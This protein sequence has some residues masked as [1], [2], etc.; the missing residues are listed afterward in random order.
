VVVSG[1]GKD[2]VDGLVLTGYKVTEWHSP[3]ARR[4]SRV[5]WVIIPSALVDDG[6][7]A[8]TPTDA[9]QIRAAGTLVFSSSSP[10]LG[11]LEIVRINR[12]A[13]SP[14]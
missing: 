6:Y 11:R 12:G 4:V 1:R 7:V 5:R 3:Q 9:D 10:T 14:A 8:M 2:T 13:V